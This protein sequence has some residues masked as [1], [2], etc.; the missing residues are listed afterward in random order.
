[1]NPLCNPDINYRRGWFFITFQVAHNK[2]VF[3]VVA[4][5]KLTHNA[6]GRMV[7]EN[8]RK[9]GTIFAE[10]IIDTAIVMP[11]HVHAVVKIDSAKRDLSYFVGRF[12]SFIAN[13][14]QKMVQA[15]AC[16]DIGPS[17]WLGATMMEGSGRGATIERQGSSEGALD[18][19]RGSNLYRGRW[20]S[21]P[22]SASPCR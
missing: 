11:N 7:D 5:R 1:M 15:G 3:G 9:L 21:V 8:L 19:G 2:T 16:V 12:K 17:L 18:D 14:Y 10:L 22:T 13:Q 6:L 20:A 4:D